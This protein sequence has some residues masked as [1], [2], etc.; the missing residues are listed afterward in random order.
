MKAKTRRWHVR[1]CT[2]ASDVDFGEILSDSHL[3]FALKRKKFSP[4]L[5]NMPALSK[6]SLGYPFEI[7]WQRVIRQNTTTLLRFNQPVVF[8]FAPK[9]TLNNRRLLSGW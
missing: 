6:M 5:S 8:R 2:I 3:G 1:K 4:R 7:N 9:R